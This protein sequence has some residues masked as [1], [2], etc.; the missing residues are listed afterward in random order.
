M[1]PCLQGLG[2]VGGEGRGGALCPQSSL[3]SRKHKDYAFVCACLDFS[4]CQSVCLSVCLSKSLSFFLPV[5][6][7]PPLS[8]SL[9]LSLSICGV[10]LAD[11]G[12]RARYR[13]IQVLMKPL[14]FAQLCISEFYLGRDQSQIRIK[15]EVGTV[16]HFVALQFFF[17]LEQNSSIVFL[18][19]KNLAFTPYCVCVCVCVCVDR[20]RCWR[21]GQ[22]LQMHFTLTTRV[23]ICVR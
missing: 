3:D 21:M 11:Q 17:L 20:P 10:D 9:S 8:L 14:L 1:G 23:G 13:A 4:V 2:C 18:N 7:S 22:W 15:S 5:S 12:S 16:K 19:V 6:P